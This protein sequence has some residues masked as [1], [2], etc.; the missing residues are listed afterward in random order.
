MEAHKKRITIVSGCYNEQD[1]VYELCDRVKKVFDRHPEYDYEQI[2]I[3]NAS[4]DRTVD[5]LREICKTN[6]NVKVIVNSRNF[7]AVRSGAHAFYMAQG[8]AVIAMA[9]DL[10][11]P[12]EMISDFIKK[13]EEGYKLVIAIKE[14]SKENFLMFALRKIYYKI[15]AS[16][17]ESVDQISNFTGFGLYDKRV[18]DEIR[19]MPDPYP[20]VRG[21]LSEIGFE[22]YEVPFTQPER[23]AGKS[24]N[25]F[26]SLLDFAM[27]GI[28]NYTNAPMR[29]ATIIGLGISTVSFL[30][31]LTYF[32]LKLLNW[33]SFQLGLAPV[34]IGLFFFGS[35]QLLFIGLIGEY[36]AA[37]LKQVKSR[38]LVVEK[39][40]INF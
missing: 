30:I 23:M 18:M 33:D 13:W 38:P 24:S 34:L 31:G 29:V 21:M 10:Q 11:D 2:L 3:D 39:E 8:D 14:K 6:K 27:L 20:Y 22:R 36:I 32:A 4:T 19:K 15:L 17:S 7:G 28:V 16:V 25:N 5:K 12:P 37:I 9:S 1:N 26:F 40:R 35:V